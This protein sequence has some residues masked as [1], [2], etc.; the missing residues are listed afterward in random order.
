M[1]RSAPFVLLAALVI[2]MV[3]PLAW[4]A[5]TASA[6]AARAGSYPAEPIA[7]AISTVTGI[8]ISPL[9]GTSAYGAYKWWI[10]KDATARAALP[11]FAQFKF[12]GPALLLVIICAAKD[13]FGAMVPPGFKKPLDILETIENKFSGLVAAGAVI[14]VA[15]EAMTRM[16]FDGKAA[17]SAPVLVHNGL[18]TIHL[19]AFD[20]SW[21]L[22]LLTVPVGVAVFA[23][24]WLASHAINVLILLSP[25]GVIDAALKVARTALLGLITITATMNPWFSA[26]LSLVVIVFAYFVAGW[27]FRLTVFGSIFSWEFVTRRCARF[28]P[29][30]DRNAMFA[31]AHLPGVPVRTYGQLV[32]QGPAGFEF[33]FRPWLVLPP[34]TAQVNLEPGLLAVGTGAF[35]SDVIDGADR[36]VF[37]LPPRYRGHEEALA[38]AYGL[39]GVRPAGWHK[40]WGELREM[41]GGRAVKR[42]SVAASNQAAV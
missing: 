17:A 28:S 34:R 29:R 2:A 24:V 13:A 8:A 37:S 1:K 31:G 18:A 12:W 5:V 19:A 41:L 33:M 40:A 21:L 15:I 9:L 38:R 20:A 10:A 25:W 11:W 22:N 7:T 3:V 23:V 30:D 32:R 39:A 14:P 35:F 26:G 4:G 27:A 36:T 42:E 16:V 6:P